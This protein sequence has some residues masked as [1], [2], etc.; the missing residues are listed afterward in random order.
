MWKR[1]WR[2]WRCLIPAVEWFE[3]E[4]AERA[5]PECGE[6]KAYKQPHFIYRADRGLV[7]VLFTPC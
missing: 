5:D 2:Q 7:C 3:W 4:A 6:I 1:A